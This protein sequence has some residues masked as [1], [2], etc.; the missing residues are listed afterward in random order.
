MES[1]AR[2]YGT[3]KDTFLGQ[4]WLIVDPF[5]QAAVYYFIFAVVLGFSRGHSNFVGYLVV[6]IISF[7]LL[8]KNLDSAASVMGAG[9]DLVRTFHFPKFSLVAA[10]TLRTYIDFLPTLVA[11]LFF[12]ILMPPHSYPTLNWLYI[13]LIYLLV[14]PFCV[15][16]A[17]IVATLTTLIP[18]IRFIIGLISRFWFY[19]SG[20][21]WTIE[22]FAG[23]P[24][25]QDVMLLNPGWV[26]LNLLRDVIVYNNTPA[27]DQF[28]YLGICSLGMFAIG[29]FVMWRNEEKMSKAMSR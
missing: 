18:D 17:S 3:I 6:G 10:Y 13:P 9:R 7:T 22:Q 5:L 14:A 11:M 27:L 8:S 19:A 24:T 21:F 15:G 4:A 12:V 25:L 29:F 1:N 20:I 26:Y 23:Q 2:A 28:I 16:M